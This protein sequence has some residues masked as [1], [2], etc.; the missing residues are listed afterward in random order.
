MIREKP[1]L[2]LLNKENVEKYAYGVMK[3]LEVFG[4]IN[5]TSQEANSILDSKIDNGH[6]VAIV[7]ENNQ[8]VS[9]ATLLLEKKLIHGGDCAYTDTTHSLIGH[10]EDVSTL[11]DCRK[12]GHARNII[13]F[14]EQKAKELG[15]YKILADVSID[16]FNNFYNGLEYKVQELCI[17]KDLRG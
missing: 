9:T 8:V 5:L 14:L 4:S 17:R 11:P 13:D 12:Q 2:V 15:C 1:M 3:C 6:L 7:V 10:L 16:N